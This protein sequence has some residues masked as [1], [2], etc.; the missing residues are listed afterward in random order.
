MQCVPPSKQ[1]SSR[2]QS[3]AQ[4]GISQSD[5]RKALAQGA[6]RRLIS[7]QKI[8]LC[9]RSYAPNLRFLVFRQLA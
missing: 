9:P 2:P 6:S 1:A 7:Y 5:V 8:A 3:Q 4:F